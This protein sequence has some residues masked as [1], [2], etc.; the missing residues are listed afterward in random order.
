MIP[1]LLVVLVLP[2]LVERS[3]STA[4]PPYAAIEPNVRLAQLQQLD[5]EG[6]RRR[7]VATIYHLFVA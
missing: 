5:L 1:A 7:R 3:R 4:R 2:V 6:A